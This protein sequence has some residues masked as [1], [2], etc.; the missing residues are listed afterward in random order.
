M[1]IE[2]LGAGCPKCRKSMEMISQAIKKTGIDAEIVHVTELNDIID[3][4]VM[5]TPAIF[6]NGKKVLEGRIPTE[7]QIKQ[8]LAK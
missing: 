4:G 3:R 6:I 7:G 1:K 5:M 2:V 8:W